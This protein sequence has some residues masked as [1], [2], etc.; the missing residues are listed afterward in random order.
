VGRARRG[1]NA[2]FYVAFFEIVRM[3]GPVFFAQFNYPVVIAGFGWGALLF[4]DA[5]AHLGRRQLMLWACAH[6]ISWMRRAEPPSDVRLYVM[7]RPRRAGFGD[8]GRRRS[9]RE[10]RWR[11]DRSPV[12]S[13]DTGAD[14]IAYGL[15]S[16]AAC[17]SAA[18]SVTKIA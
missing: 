1:V 15:W 2:A 16:V 3:A 17:L 10:H 6:T 18:L 7:P 9:T 4:G 13:C 8:H 5:S 14:P 12:S 11:P